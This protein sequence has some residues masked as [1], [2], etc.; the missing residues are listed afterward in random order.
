MYL[1]PMN[2]SVI[3]EIKSLEDG[4]ASISIDGSK[5]EDIVASIA[6][7]YASDLDFKQI[8]DVAIQL[9][10]DFNEGRDSDLDS[11]LKQISI[12]PDKSIN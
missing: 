5:L 6:T 12:N 9:S 10:K 11:Y 1:K 8:I 4:E 3:F 2:S 7:A